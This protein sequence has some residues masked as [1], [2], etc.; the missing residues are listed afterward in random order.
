MEPAYEVNERGTREKNDGNGNTSM[1]DNEKIE[2][3]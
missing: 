3:H 1:V 2:I